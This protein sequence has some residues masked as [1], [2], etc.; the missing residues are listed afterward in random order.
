VEVAV[1][2]VLFHQTQLMELVALVALALS[3]SNILK[4]H[5]QQLQTLGS[6]EAQQHGLHQLVLPTLII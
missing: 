1:A 3:S 6:L 5:Q 4:H 2:A